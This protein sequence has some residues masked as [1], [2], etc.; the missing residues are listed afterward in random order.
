MPAVRT[1][2][3]QTPAIVARE[4]VARGNLLHISTAGDDVEDEGE[5]VGGCLAR[6]ERRSEALRWRRCVFRVYIHGI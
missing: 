6:G 5:G 4:K 3:S 2:V 1:K